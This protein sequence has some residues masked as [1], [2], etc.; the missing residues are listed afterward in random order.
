MST[1]TCPDNKTDEVET[2][3]DRREPT[4]CD[5][6]GETPVPQSRST[7]ETPVPQSRSTGETPVQQTPVPQSR[8][9]SETPVPQFS[10][11]P[12]GVQ[13]EADH[14]LGSYLN[15]PRMITYWYQAAMV[16]DCGG[17]DVLEVGLGMGLTA[18]ILR[19]WGLNMSSLDLDPA[20]GPT[21]AGNVRAMPFADESFDTVLAAEVLEHLP[22][23][24]F[25]TCL[26]ELRRVCRRHVVVTLPCALAGIHVGVNLPILAP[27]FFALG[28]RQWT[29]P[30]FDGQHYWE[31]DRRGYAKRRIRRA[32]REAGFS[33]VRA[34]RPG[35]SLYNYFFVLEKI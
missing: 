5:P 7:G 6:T 9:S 11:R 14:Y 12:H 26:C 23:E 18:W 21:C 22:F 33:I 28:L 31:L 29:R 2:A 16:R 32:V 27:V 8:S 19:R 13:V 30:R 10:S 24:E 25:G 17:K 34:F 20:L 4:A 15:L 1:L 35:L 3:S